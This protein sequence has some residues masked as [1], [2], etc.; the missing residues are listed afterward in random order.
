MLILYNL[1][2]A[3][4]LIFQKGYKNEISTNDVCEYSF[5]A[6]PQAVAINNNFHF[7][8]WADITTL[9]TTSDFSNLFTR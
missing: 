1:I 7:Y 4:R 9:L 8:F 3:D 2:D 5:S 6:G